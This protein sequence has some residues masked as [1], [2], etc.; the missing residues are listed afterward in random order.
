MLDGPVAKDPLLFY[1][2]PLQLWVGRL[3]A[4][5]NESGDMENSWLPKFTKASQHLRG[6]FNQLRRGSGLKAALL[7]NWEMAGMLLLGGILELLS[8]TA[9]LGA[10]LILHELLK[11]PQSVRLA[12]LL[13]IASLCA[14]LLGRAKDQVCRVHSIWIETMLRT[15]IFEKA[16]RLS[17]GAGIAHPPAKVINMSAVD[18]DFVSTYILKF[19]DIWSAP[20]QLSA[21]AALTA[22]L[23]G[24]SALFGFLLMLFL[25]FGQSWASKITRRSY[26]SY[27]QLNDTRLGA[28]REFLV[29][30]KSVKATAYEFVYRRLVSG[31]REKQLQA[32]GHYLSA[33]F[34][35]F[36][37]FSESIPSFTA[38][39]AFLAYYLT[40]HELT[41]AVVFPALAYFNMLYQPVFAASLAIT[42]QFAVWPS[43]TRIRMFM[44][45]E[46]SAP[47]LQNSFHREPFDSSDAAVIFDNA[48]FANPSYADDPERAWKLY[49]GNLIIP[50]GKLTVVVGA[51]GSGKSSLLQAIL[52]EMTLASGEY[53]VHGTVAYAAQDAWILSGTLQDNIVFA[54][55]FD[56]AWYREVT[57]LCALEHDFQ[58]FPG[59]DGFIVGE[60]G[61]NLSGGQR[62]RIALARAI[63]A[64]PDIILL[65]DP[66]S[67]VDSQVRHALFDALR[68]VD[69]TI[70]L[71]TLHTS[72]AMQADNVIIV[73]NCRLEWSGSG[74]ELFANGSLRDHYVGESWYRELRSSEESNGSGTGQVSLDNGT[75]GE[76]DVPEAFMLVEEEE[77]A[78]GAV[79]LSVLKFYSM[80]AGGLF[81]S[82]GVSAVAAVLTGTK[83]MVN[84]WLLWWTG[85]ALLLPQDQYL[86]GYLGLTL[87]QTFFTGLLALVLVS[88]S[89]TSSRQIHQAVL[90]NI[91]SAP[92][93]FFQQQ[94]V[95]R[96]LNRLSSDVESLD[97]RIINAVDAILGAGSNL[98]ASL[99][100]ISLSSPVIVA[101]V[102]P[103]IV[104][105]AWFQLRFKA[106]AREIQRSVSVLQSPVTAILSEALISPMTIKAYNAVPFMTG[107]HGISL[108]I[109]MSAKVVQKSLDTWITLRAEMAAVGL[110]LVVAMLTAR[111]VIPGSRAGLALSMATTLSKNVYLF[112]W[113]ITD[114]EIQMNSVERLKTYH[115][116]LPREGPVDDHSSGDWPSKNMV[117][118][119]NVSLQY[120]SRRTPA[121]D[122]ISLEVPA[123]TRIG[124]V[125][126]TGSGKSTLVSSISRLV[127]ITSGSITI[128]GIDISQ[129]QPARLRQVVHSLP[130]EP[131]IL[132]GSLR[133][134]LD[135]GSLHEDQE[136]RI[137]LGVCQ[138]GEYFTA[139]GQEDPLGQTL[140]SGGTNL[141]AGQRQLVCAAR[142]LLEMP[143]IFLVDEAA[144]NVDFA[145]D[146][147]LQQALQ[148]MPST[149]TM[150]VIA[151]RAASLAWVDRVIVMDTGR[152]VEDGTP[153]EL[154]NSVAS[155]YRQVV[156]Q[157]GEAAL[158]KALRLARTRQDSR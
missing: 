44:L 5:V 115:D 151:H 36:T 139:R 103:Y 147:A 23:L 30:I 138:V 129:V 83:V 27:I 46:E 21:I 136:L 105:T 52:G 78:K 104:V 14:T 22:V 87:G 62:A 40:G 72:F 6:I 9:S 56:A 123:G 38:A 16:L 3:V 18:V 102:V 29:N 57:R 61:S 84:Y 108:D 134:N 11:D 137:T 15:A 45:A 126:R 35:V 113:A 73:E 145:S 121:L 95:G 76:E 94:P 26:V 71:V 32:L 97:F 114:V 66:L 47:T 109:L 43:L 69:S 158:Q 42:R 132:E 86:S 28:L 49:V 90:D 7:L 75:T 39:S 10:P 157:E 111:G 74:D 116:D 135:P 107:K 59:G 53:C 77:K 4:R 100:L 63:Y 149:T 81:R 122:N 98:V 85:D 68:S 17:R 118:M 65:D 117:V 148:E 156:K 48:S 133:Q 8:A 67:A 2:S 50:R 54:K 140:S 41:A 128:D 106:C 101:A 55:E 152:I 31:I 131:L 93:W 155:Y 82:A 64:R 92:L 125:G 96:I 60:S 37:A 124:I 34:A 24:P 91:L 58:S 153:F 130:Q 150:F 33:A 80:C 141:S 70:V 13:V 25:F 154:L 119:K 51:T 99:L 88:C 146:E 12:S 89:L 120:P 19:H 142:A 112:A 110:L 20:L 127:D 79:R 143:P 1:L 144:A